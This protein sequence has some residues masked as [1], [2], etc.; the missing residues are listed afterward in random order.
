[1]DNKQKYADITSHKSE[2]GLQY[3][4]FLN[5]GK[6]KQVKTLFFRLQQNTITLNRICMFRLWSNKHRT[7]CTVHLTGYCTHA[8]FHS[9]AELPLKYQSHHLYMAG[10][11]QAGRQR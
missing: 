8:A 6:R 2:T 7:A 5:H 3:T 1:M 11:K 10:S 9:A 4:M